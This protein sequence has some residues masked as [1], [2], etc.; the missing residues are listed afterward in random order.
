MLFSYELDRLFQENLWSR[1]IINSDISFFYF[2]TVSKCHE[3]VEGKLWTHH[4]SFLYR[5]MFVRCDITSKV[6]SMSLDYLHGKLPWCVGARL[7][8]V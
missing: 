5:E 1:I 3:R 6:K 2:L 7:E 4:Y 8:E